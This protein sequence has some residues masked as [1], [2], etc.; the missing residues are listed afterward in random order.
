MKELRDTQSERDD[1][2]IPIDRVGVKGLRFPVEVRDKGGSTQR[3]VATVALAVDLPEHYKGTHMSRFVEVLNSHGRCLDVREMAALPREL[4]QR[5]DAGRAHVEFEFPFFRSKPAPV[6]GKPGLMDYGIR[7]EVEATRNGGIDFAVTVKVP[8]ATLCPCSKEISDR[9][10]HNQR[11]EV[12]YSVRSREPIWIE[13]LI[14]LVERSASCELFSLLK[15]PDE[16]HVTERAYDH[17]VFVED[18]VRNVAS[19]SNSHDD[20]R[21]Y[22]VEAEN[23]ESIHNHNAYAVVE[24]RV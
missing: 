10:A 2:R 1:R 11:G 24:K 5:L 14:E 21:W 16:K 13:D 9:G 7:F 17:P 8:V 3:T 19:R 6:T 23:F 12:T 20:I 15:R 4:L 18:L 22:R